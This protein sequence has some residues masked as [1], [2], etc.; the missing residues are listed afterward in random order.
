M[1]GL[2]TLSVLVLSI[3]FQACKKE[4]KEDH[5]I[6]GPDVSGEKNTAPVAYAGA[7]TTIVLPGDSGFLKGW[8]ADLENNVISYAWKKISGPASFQIDHPNALT[9]TVRKLQKGT[10]VFEFTVTDVEGLTATDAVTIDLVDPPPP[11]HRE[12]PVKFEA[13]CPMG[14]YL[15]IRCLSCYVPDNLPFQVFLKIAGTNNWMEMV[16]NSV[17]GDG[18]IMLGDNLEILYGPADPYDDWTR[19]A[20]VKIRF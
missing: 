6:S 8:S 4:T 9:S 3:F 7:D 19:G 11:G 13:G 10:Y 16:P 20:E 18:Y 5:I 15:L 17:A 12:V 14:C 2:L 1:K